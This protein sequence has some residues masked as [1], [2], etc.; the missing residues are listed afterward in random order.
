MR[1]VGD[2]LVVIL[3]VAAAAAALCALAGALFAHFRG[4]IGY[5]HAIAWAM[6]I[7]GAVLALLVGQ[8]GRTSQMRA[9]GQV[10][11]FGTYWGRS[12]ALPESP[13]WLVVV[14]A[15]VVGLGVALYVA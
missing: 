1:R 10:G 5:T 3:A 4:G 13:L 8:S 2:A 9:E 6:W 7:G 11:L 12:A 15:L 14:S